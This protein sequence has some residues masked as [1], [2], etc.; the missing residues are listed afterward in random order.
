MNY[1]PLVSIIIPIFNVEDYIIDCLVSV[2]NQDYNN[3]EV[4]LINDKTNDKS[5]EISENIILKLRER[6][7]VII[8]EHKKNMG[9]SAARNSG[10]KTAKGAYLFFLDSDDELYPYS[11]SVL[12]ENINKYDAP[13]IISGNFILSNSNNREH[14]NPDNYLDN[15]YDIIRS[16]FTNEWPA[17]ACNKLI[18]SNFIHSHGILFK[19]GLLHED[20]LFSFLLAINA[21]KM[22]VCNQM[23]YKYRIRNSSIKSNITNKN[24]ENL[25]YIIKTEIAL[26]SHYNMYNLFY[27]YVVDKCYYICKLLYKNNVYK[28][29]EYIK[30]LR[31]VINSIKDYKSFK[32]L[33]SFKECL[34]LNSS[35]IIGLYFLLLSK[36]KHW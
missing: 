28:K 19:E 10:I 1:D 9:L 36:L 20:M 22:V 5:M 32:F 14:I 13:D 34:L 17:M 26:F 6:Y 2:L 4:V 27:S 23:T 30:D 3:L 16:F 7:H 11:I 35:F 33:F 31:V 8:I 15:N 12:A 29:N 24:I 25:I 18:K 21:E